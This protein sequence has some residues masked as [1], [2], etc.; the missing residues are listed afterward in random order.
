MTRYGRFMR[1]AVVRTSI[2]AVC[3]AIVLAGC[4]PI[5]NGAASAAGGSSTTKARSSA[6]ALPS[7][8]AARLSD[9][10]RTLRDAGFTKISPVDD[11]GRNRVVIDP[12]NW[13]VDSQSPKAGSRIAGTSTVTLQVRRP[14][15]SA[16]VST[17]IGV[18]PDVV[19]MNLQDAQNAM[20]RSGFLNL[21]SAD[22]SG[23]GRMQILDR[24][25]VVIK[26]SLRAG[27]KPGL[28]TRIVLT[29]V[30]YGESTGSSGCK[31]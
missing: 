9:A 27:T 23:Q 10:E 11:T 8:V 17:K 25:W 19:C 5:A 4:G 2:L 14:S 20:Q 24:D 28:T 7:V 15:D 30:K 12:E 31:S 16:T 13:V 22:G 26:Q 6:T 1:S 29:S 3:A 21:G 18:V